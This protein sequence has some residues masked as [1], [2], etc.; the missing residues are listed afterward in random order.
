MKFFP[1]ISASLLILGA[2]FYV[3]YRLW[4]MLPASIV[5]RVLLVTFGVVALSSFV[6]VQVIGNNLPLSL[7]ALM[8]RVG[9]SWFF[10]FI[11]L[12]IL[13]LLLELV[14]VTG[15]FPV[16]KF[17]H[18]SW[19]GLGML[20][21][22]LTLI[23]TGGYIVYLHK[24]RVELSLT[25]NKEVGA[26]RSLKI[27]AISDLHLGYGIGRK[28]FESWVKLINKENPDIVLIAGDAIDNSVRPLYERGIAESFKQINTKYGIYAS[29]GNH[30]YI[31]GI[32]NSL[33]FLK[34]AGIT[35]LRDSVAFINDTFYIVG[36][37]DRANSAR[38]S[39]E[40]LTDTLD[41]SK[42]LI[43]LDHQPYHLE[44]AERNGID[45]QIS[46]HTHHGQIFPISWITEM[47]YEKAHGY[48][49]KGDS[50]IYVSSGLGLWGGKFRIGTRSEYVVIHLKPL[51]TL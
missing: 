12:L 18:G 16:V 30:E 44:Q 39:V 40:E 32:S 14:R 6:L 49:K 2:N 35:V 50:H 4:V 42:L 29:P 22:A 43:L 51:K 41:K 26:E 10:I 5:G 45:F 36:R 27:V 37:D 13:F 9:T 46:G 25:V 15:L 47:M 38:K 48:L 11:Y 23:L 20:A 31:A 28:E 21:G 8:Y 19:Y 1:I 34:E 7:A 17:M 24:A 3:F 33:A